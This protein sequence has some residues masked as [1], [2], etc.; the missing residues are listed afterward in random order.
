MSTKKATAQTRKSAPVSGQ[1]R[2]TRTASG[3]AGDHRHQR[4][5]LP[6]TTKPVAVTRLLTRRR[7]HPERK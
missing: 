6:P 5:I 2:E 7:E 4:Q 1:Y 3:E